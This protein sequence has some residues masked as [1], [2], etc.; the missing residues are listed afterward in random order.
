MTQEPGKRVYRTFR[1]YQEHYYPERPIERLEHIEEPYE[2][3]VRLAE[4]S[5]R[6]LHDVLSRAK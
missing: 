2:Y 4:H 6:V 5:L 3:G 1:E